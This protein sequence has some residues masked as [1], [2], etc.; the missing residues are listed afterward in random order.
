MKMSSMAKMAARTRNPEQRRWSRAAT[1]AALVALVLAM[2]G[3][4]SLLGG[5]GEPATIYAPDVRV[6]PET[7]SQWP[8]VG[9]RLVVSRVYGD[10]HADSLRIAVRPTPN[11]VQVYKGAQWARSPGDMVEDTVLHALEDSGAIAEVARQGSGLAADY[12]L[13]LDLRR[14]ESDYADGATPQATIEI[15]AKLLHIKDQQL[16]GAR[17]F[18]QAVPAG[19]TAVPAVVDAFEQGLQAVGGELAGWA[20]TTGDAYER[21]RSAVKR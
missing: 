11:E 1:A 17:T 4:A 18:E 6:A 16:A 9:W 10:R 19:G 7:S 8:R 12:R 21:A 15:T 5:G 14:F 3:C 2:S 20:L 13:L